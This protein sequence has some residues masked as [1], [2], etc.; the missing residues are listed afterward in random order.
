MAMTASTT[1]ERGSGED[2]VNG[3]EVDSHIHQSD[4][5]DKSD[6]IF[7]KADDDDENG[8]YKSSKMKIFPEQRSLFKCSYLA[9]DKK[10]LLD[11]EI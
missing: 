4:N 8:I 7:D 9:V 3:Q 5:N 6:K 10:L 1:I 11:S 2:N